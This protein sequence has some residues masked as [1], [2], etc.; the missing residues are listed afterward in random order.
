MVE[1]NHYLSVT[2][3]TVIKLLS[4][5]DSP[6]NATVKDS[7]L[8]I[9][10]IAGAISINLPQILKIKQK[11]YTI[12]DLTGN[13]SINN[14]TINAFLGNT[15]NNDTSK[16][17]TNP[18]ESL[19][20]VNDVVSRWN[21]TSSNYD[22][23]TIGD[24]V[25]PTSSTDNAIARWDMTTGKLLLDSIGLLDDVGALSGLTQLN[26]GDLQFN[27]N[28][29]TSTVGDIEIN[30]FTNFVKID[31]DAQITGNLIV[32]G[33]TTSTE[34]ENVLIS[35][36]YIHNN[37]NYITNVA[38]SGGLT[39]RYLPTTTDD[40]VN[41]NFT[42]GIIAVSNP[43][44]ITNGTNT[45]TINDIIAIDSANHSS[46]NG[47]YE[48]LSH[49]AN[50]LTIRGIGITAT[51]EEFTN[52]Q[53]VTDTI[54]A[55]TI[56]KINVSIIR[57][58]DTGDWQFGKGNQTPIIFSS[59]GDVIGPASSTDHAIVRWHET[60]G[61]IIQ[62]SDT[63]LNDDEII[64]GLASITLTEDTDN[65]TW[66]GFNAG[67]AS[68]ADF[69]SAFGEGAL[70][71]IELGGLNNTA[72]GYQAGNAIT[73]GDYNTSV[74]SGAGSN[75][76]SGTRSIAIGFLAGSAHTG[77]NDRNI[78]IGNV[79]VVGTSNT[80]RIGSSD[81]T[82]TH[83][84]GQYRIAIG[85]NALDSVTTTGTENIAVG[86]NAL[87][88]LVP[89]GL[90]LGN[91]NIAIGSNAGAGLVTGNRNTIIGDNAMDATSLSDDCVAIGANAL[92][93]YTEKV[94]KL[95][96][97]GSG[98]LGAGLI[99][100]TAV[101]LTAIGYQA[102]NVNTSGQH[103]TA[104]GHRALATTSIAN[105]NTAMGYQALAVTTNG[106]STAIGASA[107][108][109]ATAGGENVAI[110]YNALSSVTT[111]S[112]LTAVGT[113]ALEDNTTGIE[114]VA[115]GFDALSSNTEG[116]GNTAVGFQ[117][118]NKNTIG[119]R[120]TAIGTSALTLTISTNF[121]T[122]LGY[123]A[124][125]VATAGGQNTAIG[126]GALSASSGGYEN[127]AVG[128]D[129]LT[130]L[131]NGINNVAVG[132]D[133]GLAITDADNTVA[134]G[135]NALSAN[136]VVNELT[137][138]GSGA[139]A[140]AITGTGG[141]TAVGYMALNANLGG[142]NNT[143]LGHSAGVL[144][145]S[146][147]NNTVM[148]YGAGDVI[149][150]G[151]RHTAIGMDALGDMTAQNDCTMVGYQAGLRATAQNNV[152]VGVQSFRGNG[153]TA[154][155]GQNNISVGYRSLSL[156][157]TGNNNVA[158]GFEALYN[159]ASG[160]ANIAIG[161]D[162][163]TANLVQT[164]VTAIG[165]RSMYN[166]NKTA[167]GTALQSVALGY[168]TLFKLKPG[169]INGGYRCTAIGF[170]ALST[171]NPTGTDESIDNTVVGHNAGL[172]LTTGSRNTMLGSQV[173][174]VIETGDNNTLIGYRSGITITT[175]ANNTIIGTN[176]GGFTT[177]TN[178]IFLGKDSG[179]LHTLADSNN[180][181]IE[182]IG[183]V[184][185]A[186]IRIGTFATHT[187]T[188]LA[189]VANITPA[190]N[191]E[192]VV[193]DS[194]TGEMGSSA[195]GS[196][197]I[198]GDVSGP[199][200]G[201]STDHAIVR[202]HETTGKIIQNSATLLDD[203]DVISGLASI[204]LTPD[205]SNSTWY[206]F[207][208]GHALGATS[209]VAF[210]EGALQNIA[211]GGHQNIAVGWRT[212]NSI[213]TGK[214]N[215]I[216]GSGA[217]QSIVSGEYNIA[218]GY[219]AGV[220]HTLA[221]SNNI[222]IGNTGV[223]GNSY[224]IRLG[225]A[226]TKTHIA[227]QYI[228]AI[229]TNALGTTDLIGG[230]TAEN[231][232]IGYN[233]LTGLDIVGD[234][235]IAIG[236]NAGAGLFTGNRN[237]I[238][239]DNAMDATSLSDDCV[240]IGTNALGTY[241]EEVHQLTAIGSGALGAGLI[242]GN[243]N[244]TA[245]GY[246][247]LNAN[248][249][250]ANNT[251]VGHSASKNNIDGSNNTSVGYNSMF[252]GTNLS[253]NTSIGSSTLS[254]LNTTPTAD[255]SIDGSFGV[256]EWKGREVPVAFNNTTSTLELQNVYAF[257]KNTGTPTTSYLYM[258]FKILGNFSEVG[259]VAM[260]VGVVG[261]TVNPSIPA[262]GWNGAWSLAIEVRNSIGTGIYNITDSTWKYNDV[263]A[264]NGNL[265]APPITG[266]VIE[267]ASSGN[268]NPQIIEYSV[269]FD[270][271]EHA[272]AATYTEA[273]AILQGDTLQIVGNYFDG[274]GTYASIT[275]PVAPLTYSDPNEYFKLG[276]SG[277]ANTT[278]G[279]Q[280]LNSLIEGQQNVAIGVNSMHL[281]EIVNR[282][283]AVG[284][285][286]LE[287]NG[288][289]GES[290]YDNTAIGDSAAASL[291]TGNKN[292]VG[293]SSSLR[294]LVSGS[295]NTSLGYYAGSAIIAGSNNIFIGN[296]AGS[297]LTTN[298]S[299]NILIGNTGTDGDNQKIVIGDSQ[300]SAFIHGIY[301]I[302][303]GAGSNE[304][305]IIDMD[306]Q[307]GSQAL[308]IADVTAAAPMTDKTIIIG[309]GGGKG[310]QDSTITVTNDDELAGVQSIS[311]L[312]DADNNTAFGYLAGNSSGGIRNVAF[313]S[314]ALSITA[315]TR[316]T[317][318]GADALLADTSGFD[319]VA[320]GDSALF[321]SV[322]GDGNIAIGSG[323]GG[324]LTT[325]DSNNII[326]GNSGSSGDNNVIKIGGNA[327]T[328]T[329]IGGIHSVTPLANIQS[330]IINQ[331]GQLGSK[332]TFYRQDNT[333]YVTTSIFTGTAV[334]GGNRVLDETN[335]LVAGDYI[336]EVGYGWSSGANGSRAFMSR[337]TFDGVI[338]GNVKGNDVTH[339][340]DPRRTS[341]G[342]GDG[343]LV[344][345]G[346]DQQY[347]WVMKYILTGITAGPKI[348]LLDYG[349]QFAGITAAL[350]GIWNTYYILTR[351]A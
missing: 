246:E 145:T 140:G 142:I 258:G 8:C 341:G 255:P 347:N 157:E 38:Q 78:N 211:S 189:G 36:N 76:V 13:A 290:S 191:V 150:T 346:T 327:H 20:L 300:T 57:S 106:Q 225:D 271:L 235:N 109:L 251:S 131:F 137:A 201:N 19:S 44:V 231:I 194:T 266:P 171:M 48:V 43:T 214:F 240:A 124:L 25:G 115:V 244:L 313:G 176:A 41:G 158:L 330:V 147:N 23:I 243:G 286:S 222:N 79:G 46:N 144:I 35:S 61:K 343:G 256:G 202:W 270:W 204:T 181:N 336:L 207:D 208:A 249:S 310:I 224:T 192:I 37:S 349:A 259:S 18:Y 39:V 125:K 177:G 130:A 53:F 217:G 291:T 56:T 185:S 306:G 52:N 72:F 107:L 167:A 223:T 84:A 129:T 47:I 66:Y 2:S 67:H 210:G 182:H 21:I 288:G 50:I 120:N 216:I 127:V 292:F 304:M 308:P 329:M 264:T 63:V 112:K 320:I 148:G 28:L 345:T 83:I 314:G 160:T 15:I 98:A 326:I 242:T 213:T 319:S 340:Q 65:S 24:V 100:A 128:V 305:V 307:L 195:V 184:E 153:V 27:N 315:S 199:G 188:F 198:I 161:S 42:A 269:R 70:Q 90:A 302:A 200:T 101:G 203:A 247:A 281:S 17:L 293:G 1:Q 289:N 16:I 60:T 212:G 303:P 273:G 295:N 31:S 168:E 135:N 274:D 49:G 26:V 163:F 283:T 317:A 40:T 339:F 332:E 29:I 102:L 3:G 108:T 179:N 262:G 73:T 117:A 226:Q 99:T 118:L 6:Y 22:N 263:S 64:S 166:A 350:A 170:N 344:D 97:I 96:A 94:D 197:T 335:T 334:P 238:I 93:T 62:D 280:T 301:S 82:M 206:G 196:G 265:N 122:A 164:G 104:V 169:T 234:D 87:T 95:V 328:F 312:A 85:T 152:G 257:L 116:F 103:N 133:A 296:E 91:D 34:S 250:G 294:L 272:F 33:T 252:L 146:G 105:Y 80:M 333:K 282:C 151:H 285:A 126:S 178:N 220:A 71:N 221:D 237:T 174:A 119:T 121:N 228:I 248:T 318:I 215:T 348:L 134:I 309:D 86:Y 114:N 111:I 113:N 138:V 136:T 299:N 54:A 155:S 55:G 276:I 321:L 139:L 68:G 209:T 123:Q 233:A 81:Q 74:G 183:A 12:L 175:G 324:A 342:D 149:T 278:V 88:G 218:I 219:V 322:S 187:S 268:T 190:S 287:N 159:N 337:I 253:N 77:V 45:F 172:V 239:G 323:A 92:G 241:T 165:H 173:G 180:I 351:I 275:Y 11:T 331:D 162:T 284:H 230:T 260:N 89:V 298:D 75:M 7:I 143:A 51:I 9:D 58:N 232:A 186:T 132:H 311:L 338:L 32:K 110:G 4:A 193:I 227:G 245:M 5:V 297:F 236:S 69:N 30:P 254:A 325:N 10:T 267:F 154:N 205:P 279:Y 141:L 14:I 156:N 59:I 277:S 261:R 229:G 316:N